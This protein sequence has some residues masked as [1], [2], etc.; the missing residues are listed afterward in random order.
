M[1]P[2]NKWLLS[3]KQRR[4]GTCRRALSSLH[5][6]KDRIHSERQKT[7]LQPMWTS[8]HSTMRTGGPHITAL[9]LR[10]ICPNELHFC[11]ILPVICSLPGHHTW[12]L[13]VLL[14]C[15]A[16]SQGLCC[17][18]RCY[19]S[20]NSKPLLWELLI[21]CVSAT[22]VWDIHVSKFLFVFVCKSLFCHKGHL[23]TKNL[24]GLRKH[25]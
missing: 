17:P 20:W 23:Q 12:I 5:L 18:R 9:D 11:P 25:Y 21:L 1:S 6:P 16:T 24:Q 22:S 13:K 14:H 3:Q 8:S 7:P 4:W 2:P 10:P 15:L 19:I